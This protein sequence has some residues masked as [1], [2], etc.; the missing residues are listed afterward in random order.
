M[1]EKISEIPIR[2]VKIKKLKE[3]ILE[4]IDK[5]LVR[6][7]T[8]MKDYLVDN[9]D[10]IEDWDFM[11]TQEF[12]LLRLKEYIENDNTFW[13]FEARYNDKDI[14]IYKVSDRTLNIWLQEDYNFVSNFLY[15]IEFE[16]FSDVYE[17]LN[18]RYFGYEFT[19]IFD[20]IQYDDRMKNSN[21]TDIS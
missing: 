15:K 17:I 4:E 7:R 19:N 18:D 16:G 11:V 2:E 14:I 21:W 13:S 20:E 9:E 6:N 5:Y 1:Y 3:K 8:D 12:S 10:V